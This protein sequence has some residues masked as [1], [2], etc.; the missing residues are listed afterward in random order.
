MSNVIQLPAQSVFDTPRDVAGKELM[1]TNIS[2]T[3]HLST[4]QCCS[5]MEISPSNW[6]NRMAVRDAA[7]NSTTSFELKWWST[8]YEIP[9]F[10]TSQPGSNRAGVTNMTQ[11]HHPRKVLE[12]AASI[13]NAE[14]RNLL[15]NWLIDIGNEVIQ[16][17]FAIDQHALTHDPRVAHQLQLQP[18]W[19]DW[20]EGMAMLSCALIYD[21]NNTCVDLW[22]P[23][24][25]FDR[26]K[27]NRT[28]RNIHGNLYMAQFGK[29]AKMLFFERADSNLLSGGTISHLN[30]GFPGL[31]ELQNIHNYQYESEIQIRFGNLSRILGHIGDLKRNGGIITTETWE[32]AS[33]AL[34]GSIYNRQVVINNA[35]SYDLSHYRRR[36]PYR[37][38]SDLT[39][40]QVIAKY[41]G[42]PKEYDTK[43]FDRSNYTAEECIRFAHYDDLIM[44]ELTDCLD[45]RGNIVVNN[46]AA[47]YPVDGAV[48]Q[49]V[50]GSRGFDL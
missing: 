12:E 5:L 45:E 26:A 41:E 25:S 8:V 11:F 44:Y 42:F 1:L 35:V 20:R 40:E 36:I 49:P 4:D 28:C 30:P 37:Y 19:K 29:P 14:K 43:H 32:R 6:A 13:R 46:N 50:Q 9:V 17:G 21:V 48:S 16:H 34:T 22:L 10:Y 23:D 38:R 27:A 47:N 3:L 31:N 18:A 33:V 7:E 24:G 39:R 15:V 2:G